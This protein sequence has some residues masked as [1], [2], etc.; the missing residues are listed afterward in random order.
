M[1]QVQ[2]TLSML[3]VGSQWTCTAEGLPCRCTKRL[4]DPAP[5]AREHSARVDQCQIG[6]GEAS[7][8][9]FAIFPG[10]P[11]LRGDRRLPTSPSPSLGLER[12]SDFVLPVTG[13]RWYGICPWKNETSS[14]WPTKCQNEDQH[15]AA[16][17]ATEVIHE[18]ESIDG[19]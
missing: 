1:Q 3:D 16:S 14:H 10:H 11:R 5:C 6:R 8:A 15:E 2:W 19:Y 13:P 7:I 17:N 12:G 9:R 4:C 18:T